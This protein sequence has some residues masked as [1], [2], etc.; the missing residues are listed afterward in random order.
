VRLCM[1]VHC[2]MPWY[3]VAMCCKL[4]WVVIVAVGFDGRGGVVLQ[5]H[6]M[7]WVK[8]RRHVSQRVASTPV[9][10]NMLQCAQYAVVNFCVLQHS[11]RWFAQ[12]TNHQKKGGGTQAPLVS[13][14]LCCYGKKSLKRHVFSTIFFPWHHGK[15]LR[16][17]RRHR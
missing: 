6:V 3:V 15:A 13:A 4:T 8:T 9:V 11:N 16:N 10:L 17:H 1:A 2:N 12:Q 5:G 14:F 7:R